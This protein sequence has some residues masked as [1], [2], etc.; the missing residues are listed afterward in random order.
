M[1]Q[2]D[3]TH[4]QAAELYGDSP[5]EKLWPSA[6]GKQTTYL[7]DTDTDELALVEY[8]R[9]EKETFEVTRT[10][11][12]MIVETATEKTI[13]GEKK[14][15]MIF[16]AFQKIKKDV[17]K[18]GI[19]P[20][21]LD[22][23]FINYFIAPVY[24]PGFFDEFYCYDINGAYPTTMLNEGFINQDTYDYVMKQKKDIRL[25]AIGMLA[26]NATRWQFIE[27]EKMSMRTETSEWRD[28]FFHVSNIVDE[29]LQ[30]VVQRERRNLI[31]YWVDGIFVKKPSDH[32]GYILEKCGYT[33]KI[34]RCRRFHV[35]RKKGYSRVYFSKENKKNGF[36]EK[37]I[38]TFR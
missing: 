33:F 1:I 22:P 4:V 11:S 14:S 21:P 25:P 24:Q 17:K 3:Y 2:I 6:R 19:I 23:T 7:N 13:I 35:K 9:D 8:L 34:E 10:P 36:F 15:K 30:I 29:A 38:F 12:T 16:P 26:R 32:I 37:K 18:C 28:Y 27:G 20:L 31:F 5:V